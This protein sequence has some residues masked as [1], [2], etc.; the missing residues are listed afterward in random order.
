M[1]KKSLSKQSKFVKMTKSPSGAIKKQVL[2]PDGRWYETKSEPPYRWFYDGKT[3]QIVDSQETEKKWNDFQREFNKPKPG[4]K[5]SKLHEVKPEVWWDIESRKTYSYDG[6][7]WRERK[8]L[9]SSI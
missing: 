8:G 3:T 7:K 2:G 9:H 1:K 4:W 5:H 6:H